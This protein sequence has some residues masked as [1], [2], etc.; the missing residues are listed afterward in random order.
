ME[1]FA[2]CDFRYL[3]LFGVHLLICYVHA[4]L[5]SIFLC[6]A[7][8]SAIRTQATSHARRAHEGKIA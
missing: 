7:I 6:V 8:P 2:F 3:Y 4:S 1:K 5:S